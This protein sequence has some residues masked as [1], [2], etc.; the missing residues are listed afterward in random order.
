[1]FAWRTGEKLQNIGHKS[2]STLTNNDW[3]MPVHQEL[4]PQA[5]PPI[6]PNSDKK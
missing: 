5:K 6:Q 2:R 3:S 4:N 1:M